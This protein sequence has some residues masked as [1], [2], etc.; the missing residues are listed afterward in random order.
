MS[1][2]SS[3]IIKKLFFAIDKDHKI[4]NLK[5][6][7]D[8]ECEYEDFADYIDVIRSHLIAVAKP[9]VGDVVVSNITKSFEITIRCIDQG[10]ILKIKQLK[11]KLT[12]EISSIPNWTQPKPKLPDV[13]QSA[14]HQT[15]KAG[16]KKIIYSCVVNLPNESKEFL[17]SDRKTAENA[18][19]RWV[20]DN[21]LETTYID[22]LTTMPSGKSVSS[23][24]V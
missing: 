20:I 15:T 12:G 9:I 5:C 22:F 4:Y 10:Q 7:W 19:V 8:A 23:R 17:K 16:N 18:A 21:K 3:D 6:R 13:K 1:T 14:T 11:T 24:L 2:Q